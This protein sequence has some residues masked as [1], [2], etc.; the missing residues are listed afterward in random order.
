M[1]LLI[2]IEGFL[3]VCFAALFVFTLTRSVQR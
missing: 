1:N 3:G 2:E